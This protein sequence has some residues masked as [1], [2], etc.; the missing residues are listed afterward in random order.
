MKL[1][2]SVYQ[3]LGDK[4]IDWIMSPAAITTVKPD[5]TV[6]NRNGGIWALFF[7]DPLTLAGLVYVPW[8]NNDN[9]F[10]T[11]GKKIMQA[12]YRY[13]IYWNWCRNNRNM[14]NRRWYSKLFVPSVHMRTWRRKI[15]SNTLCHNLTT[16]YWKNSVSSSTHV[17]RREKKHVNCNIYV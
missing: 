2:C 4:R 3:T 7:R 15:C 13:I 14:I 5:D 17:L 6:L 10:D 12:F 8:V 1:G 11:I 9:E 16:I